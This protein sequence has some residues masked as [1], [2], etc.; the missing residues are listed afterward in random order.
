M[1]APVAVR[2]VPH[3]VPVDRFPGHLKLLLELGV[4]LAQALVILEYIKDLLK[5]GASFPFK[6]G[7][8]FDRGLAGG[9][10]SRPCFTVRG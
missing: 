5:V 2:A 10:C 4:L 7:Q 6:G 9:D 1:D 3:T 8:D